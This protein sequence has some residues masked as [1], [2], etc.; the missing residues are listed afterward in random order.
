MKRPPQLRLNNVMIAVSLVCA[1]FAALAMALK[2]LPPQVGGLSI[3][4]GVMSSCLVAAGWVL[5]GRRKMGFALGL[6]GGVFGS[7][8]IVLISRMLF[9]H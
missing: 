2:A 1:A 3:W 7:L 5:V 6:I 9:S 4:L 8:T